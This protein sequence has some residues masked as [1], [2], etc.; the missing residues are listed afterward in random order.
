MPPSDEVTAKTSY[1]MKK[2]LILNGY[3]TPKKNKLLNIGQVISKKTVE[4]IAK[5]DAV[6]KRS[7]AY[8]VEKRLDEV[9]KDKPGK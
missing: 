6:K 1:V 4:F 3:P 5:T 2:S 9:K 7:L 8:F